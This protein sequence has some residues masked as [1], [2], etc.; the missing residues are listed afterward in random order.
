MGPSPWYRIEEHGA[1]ILEDV[2]ELDREV[3]WEVMDEAA[4]S[5]MGYEEYARRHRELFLSIFNSPGEQ[6]FFAAYDASGR[7]IGVA[8][9]K[10]EMD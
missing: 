9:V 5:S 10:E 8:W 2:L 3:S 1:E 6:R 4:R 7:L